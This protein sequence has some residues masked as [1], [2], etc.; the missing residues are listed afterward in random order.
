VQKRRVG[1]FG[2]GIVA[3]R[4]PDI[5]AFTRNLECTESWLT[6]FR[7]FG[8][9][10]FLVGAPQFDFAAYREWIAERFPPSRF[11]QL[12]EKMD[13]PALYA[14]GSFIQSLRQNPGLEQELTR[15]GTR[16]HIYVG[17]GLGSLQTTGDNALALDRAQRRW[18]RF[19]SERN[20]ELRDWLDRHGERPVDAAHPGAPPDGPDGMPAD[21][22]TFADT[23]DGMDNLAQAQGAWWHF[24][25]GRCPDLHTYL[26][27]LAAIDGVSVSGD[28]ERGKMS[29]LKEKQRRQ[30]QLQKQWGAP[31]PPWQSVSANLV[32]NIQNT[33][34]SQI[35]MLGHITGMAFAPVAACSTFGVSLKLGMDAIL[36]GRATAVVVGATDPPPLALSVGAF[37]NAR[38]IAADNQVSKPLTGLRGTHVAGGSVVWVLGDLDHMLERG[39]KPLGM[40]PLAVGVSADADHIITPSP[41]GPT[42]AIRQAL[43]E[44]GVGPQ[45]IGSWDLHAT[46]TPGDDLEVATL[47]S[48]LPASVLVTARKGT[49]GH[50]MSAGS[51]WELTAQYLGYQRGH[52]Y[53]TGL[54]Q[55]EL[56]HEIAARHNL[57][58]FDRPCDLPAGAAGKL[59]MGIGGINA[60]VVSRPW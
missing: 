37:Y 60:C 12:E 2:W 40:E 57:F 4:S 59:S 9:N 55:S 41:E 11:R 56:N 24:W 34:A 33:P 52:L 45:E 32:W 28:V 8:P 10:N 36:S 44:S 29:V 46:A 50:G 15:L 49:F 21:P 19:W 31:V 47:R 17:T 20:P 1:I 16:A 18:D 42:A 58:V 7:G 27:E 25:A 38:V 43:E 14:V 53:P 6:P 48:L 35:S 23:L 13:L 22:R 3:P 5:D 26:A 51:G 30:A 39:F 54:A